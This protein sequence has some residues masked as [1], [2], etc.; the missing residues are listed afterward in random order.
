MKKLVLLIIVLM[1]VTTACASASG[2]AILQTRPGAEYPYPLSK[3]LRVHGVDYYDA[4]PLLKAQQPLLPGT[5]ALIIGTAAA[6]NEAIQQA[7]AERKG[8]LEAMLKQGGVIVELCQWDQFEPTLS[9]L[10]GKLWAHRCDTDLRQGLLL[11][12]EHPLFTAPNHLSA[13]DLNDWKYKQW[14]TYWETFDAERNFKILAADGKH[15]DHPFILEGKYGKGR[16]LLAC[17]ARDWYWVAGEDERTRRESGKLLENLLNYVDLVLK[18]QAPEC[19]PTP[20]YQPERVPV[21]VAVWKDANGNGKQDAGEPPFKGIQVSDCETILVTDKTGQVTFECPVEVAPWISVS[22]PSG[23]KATTPFFYYTTQKPESAPRKLAFGLAPDPASAPKDRPL[24]F[25][26]V[27]DLHVGLLSP[28]ADDA[29]YLAEDM[30]ALNVLKSKLDFVVATGDL[31]NIGARKD[32]WD[33]Y[34]EGLKLRRLPWFNVIGNHDYTRTFSDNSNY[35]AYCGPTFYSWDWGK[36]H[37]IVMDSCSNLYGQEKWLLRDFKLNKSKPIVLFLHYPPTP[38]QVKLFEKHHVRLVCSGHWH[39]NKVFR[40]KKLLSVNTPPLRFGG[41]DC[42][43]RGFRLLEL[44]QDGQVKASFVEL[45][46]APF[47]ALTFPAPGGKVRPGEVPVV[48]SAYAGVQPVGP[49]SWE[50]SSDKLFVG[51]GRLEKKGDMTWVGKLPARFLQLGKHYELKVTFGGPSELAPVSGDFTCVASLPALVP[52]EPWVEFRKDAARS[53][54]AKVR[55]NAQQAALAWASCLPSHVEIGSPVYGDGLLVVPQSSDDGTGFNGLVALAC[56]DGREIWRCATDSAVKHSPALDLESNAVCALTVAG[57]AYGVDLHTG[58]IKWTRSLGEPASRYAY[59]APLV[60]KG[61]FVVG[62]A[63]NVVKLRARDGKVLWATAG[64]G[65]DWISSYSSPA[66]GNGK[67]F[68][69]FLGGPGTVALDWLTGKPDW[70]NGSTGGAHASD[71]YFDQA[72]YQTSTGRSMN[73]LDVVTGKVR[74]SLGAGKS[75]WNVGTP[76]VTRWRTYVPG[77]D[78]VLYCFDQETHKLLWQFATGPARLSFSPYVR[79]GSSIHSSPILAGDAVVF[80]SNDGKLYAL[81]YQT[82]RLL[83]SFDLGAPV[84]GTPLVTGNVL[85]VTTYQ[86]VAYAFCLG[87]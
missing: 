43:A 85:V 29:R 9:W 20:P 19:K 76:L 59:A 18:G 24:V 87:S 7:L 41:I 49:V 55:A 11:A 16:V 35:L 70:K 8:A 54:L 46:V 6:N 26:Q 21:T 80:G 57:K 77:A 74:N 15:L 58:K 83:W 73:Q 27:T 37:F 56:L 84:L 82:G 39:S 36:W 28:Q 33:E 75:G 12:P 34:I 47:A 81:D 65:G 52:G 30:E 61:C 2:I 5:K 3:F 64:L 44:E 60:E 72:V 79:N 78:G 40:Y 53:G 67:V 51:R 10:P 4:L 23:Y 66:F 14:S 50:L 62:S 69:T 63:P 42:A 32:Q 1:V 71:V 22:V 31:V 13:G 45:P 25:A 38:E 48:V 86:G 17:V 68:W